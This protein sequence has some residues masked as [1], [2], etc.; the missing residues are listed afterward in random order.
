[1]RHAAL[2]EC[3]GADLTLLY[4]PSPRVDGGRHA[5]VR[6]QVVKNMP[7]DRMYEVLGQLKNMCVQNREHARE[8]FASHPHLALAVMRMQVALSLSLPMM[9]MVSEGCARH[10][11]HDAGGGT[12]KCATATCTRRC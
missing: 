3:N 2:C 1:M 8:L 4:C 10:R 6:A 12:A 11:E 5:C 7:P 9:R